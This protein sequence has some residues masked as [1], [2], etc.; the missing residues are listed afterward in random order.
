MNLAGVTIL[1]NPEN[2]VYENILSYISELDYLVLFDNSE[3]QNKD[4]I[5]KL[6]QLEKVEYISL[7]ENKGVSYALNIGAKKAIEKGFKYLLTMDQDNKFPINFLKDMK[8]KV[9]SSKIENVGIYAPVQKPNTYQSEKE[10]KEYY[11]IS[12]DELQEI[13]L[14]MTSAC[15]VDLDILKKIGFYSEDLFIDFIDIEICL[16]LKLNNYKVIRFNKLILSHNL[17]KI[18]KYNLFFKKG[19]FNLHSPIRLYYIFR[20][21]LHLSNKYKKINFYK[22]YA[23][24]VF[25]TKLIHILVIREQVFKSLKYIIKALLDYKKGK[26]GKIEE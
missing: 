26:I 8:D 7:N 17:G 4:L 6:K 12:D 5:N 9:K 21:G 19:F 14:V 22:N 24:P 10:L 13:E 16:R 25:I 23:K 18:V 3:R 11:H 1:Y 15:I 20:D 2:S